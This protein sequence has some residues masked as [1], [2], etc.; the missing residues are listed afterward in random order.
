[1][2]FLCT[3]Q[4]QQNCY[5]TETVRRGE[6]CPDILHLTALLHLSKDNMKA[7]QF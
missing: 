7:G 5:I 1:M 2:T 4:S 6:I 3:A